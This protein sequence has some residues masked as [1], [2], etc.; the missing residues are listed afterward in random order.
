MLLLGL[1]V[2]LLT[3]SASAAGRARRGRDVVP[4]VAWSLPGRARRRAVLRALDAVA[5]QLLVT[6]GVVATLVVNRA[7]PPRPAGPAPRRRAGRAPP[8]GSPRAR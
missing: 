4:V 2:N 1:E 8:P 7:R 6:A 5:L 3:L